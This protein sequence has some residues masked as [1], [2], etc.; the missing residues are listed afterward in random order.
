MMTI[1]LL[2]NQAEVIVRSRNAA[3]SGAG[4]VFGNLNMIETLSHGKVTTEVGIV[5]RMAD[6]VARLY[7]LLEGAPGSDER[8]ED[9]LLD[10]IGYAA[11]L[12]LR[13]ASRSAPGFIA[14]QNLL[15]DL[16]PSP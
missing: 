8:L 12:R 5:I 16:P 9:T 2:C 6:K 13:T 7:N 3:Y 10:L 14:L 11:L 1:R 4:D 15:K